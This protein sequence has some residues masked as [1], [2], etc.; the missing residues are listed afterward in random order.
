MAAICVSLI[1]LGGCADGEDR[2]NQAGMKIAARASAWR[3]EF[4][5]PAQPDSSRM[6]AARGLLSLD[7]Q[8]LAARYVQYPQLVRGTIEQ[9]VVARDTTCLPLLVELFETRGGEER[10]EFEVDLIAFGAAAHPHLR[11]LLKRQDRG[12]VVRAADA[13]AKSGAEAAT[14]DIAALLLHN[15]AWIR[16]GAAHALG[17]LRGKAATDALLTALSD[18]AYAVINAAL[19]GLASQHADVACEPALVLLADSRPE[20]RKH[21]AHTL[22]QLGNPA[23][24]E[25]LLRVSEQDPDD[26]VRFMASRALQAL[27]ATP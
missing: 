27:A 2:W 5:D 4:D 7:P 18:S 8:F 14:T 10:I 17:Q 21:A 24:R 15:D 13:L 11:E 1:V 26:G 19:V 6:A 16:M 9:A 23:A 22:G 12:L 20:V 3:H 25:R